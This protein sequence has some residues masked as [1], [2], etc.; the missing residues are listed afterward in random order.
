MW[1]VIYR[2]K[3]KTKIEMFTLQFTFLKKYECSICMSKWHK[4]SNDIKERTKYIWY[5]IVTFFKEYTFVNL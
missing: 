2:Y 5:T 1:I 3:N 4:E